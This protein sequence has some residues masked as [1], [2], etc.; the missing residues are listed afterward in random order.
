MKLITYFQLT[1][2]LTLLVCLIAVQIKAQ[3]APFVGANTI[4]LAI[5]L[6]DQQAYKV[7]TAVLTEQSLSY[8]STGNRLLIRSQNNAT[9]ATKGLVFE[10]QL[11]LNAG[12]IELT[13]RMLTA[14][15]GDNLSLSTQGIPIHFAKVRDT[16]QRVGFIYM[17]GLAKHL[18]SAL[19]SS[20]TYKYQANTI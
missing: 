12:V 6:D 7:I 17:D 8:T 19:K 5:L 3:S 18:Q 10:G 9:L 14:P 20:L 4:L 11:V 1:H 2:R 13:G 16:V 15:K